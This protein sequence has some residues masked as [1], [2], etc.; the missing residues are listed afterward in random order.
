MLLVVWGATPATRAWAEQVK[1]VARTRYLNM[2]GAAQAREARRDFF[3]RRN[4]RYAMLRIS[5]AL[6]R[7]S[8]FFNLD[9]TIVGPLPSRPVL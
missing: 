4:L 5:C 8:E 1:D 7:D 6:S 9:L 2:C 3:G